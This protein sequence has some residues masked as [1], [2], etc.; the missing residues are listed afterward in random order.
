MPRGTRHVLTGTLRRTRL[1]YSLE[2]D[3]GGAWRLDFGTIWRVG[4]YVDRR[5]TVE[6]ARS[7]FDLLD[8]YRLKRERDDWP[9]GSSWT[10]RFKRWKMRSR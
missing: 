6:G 10:Q 9:P 8:V 1:G 7:D 4:R 2:M 3:G 5:V